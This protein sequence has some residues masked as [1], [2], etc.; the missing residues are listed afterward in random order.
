M[1]LAIKVP[2]TLSKVK[3]ALDVWSKWTKTDDTKQALGYAHNTVFL[4]GGGAW[5]QWV[6]DGLIEADRALAE[7]VDAI[8]DTMPTNQTTA[9][10]HFHVAKVFT[11]RRTNIE[12]DYA[13]G[14]ISIEI[15]LRKRNKL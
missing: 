6:D 8:M 9:I 4:S 11:P 10:T 15:G 7:A 2:D 14:L 13:D 3:D 1:S 12:Q 5:G